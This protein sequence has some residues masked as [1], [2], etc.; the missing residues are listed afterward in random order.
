MSTT[1]EKAAVDEVPQKDATEKD[2]E[3]A[4]PAKG[5]EKLLAALEDPD[6][7]LSDEERAKIVCI[8]TIDGYC[9]VY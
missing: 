4:L 1:D 8:L 7:G 2:A 6:A 9:W 3:A 5:P